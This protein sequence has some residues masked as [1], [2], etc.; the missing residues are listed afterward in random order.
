MKLT[1]YDPFPTEPPGH[2]SGFSQSYLPADA[3]GTKSFYRSSWGQVHA[4]H[5]ICPI[6]PPPNLSC[7]D[8]FTYS[9]EN[10]M[11]S[12]DYDWGDQVKVIYQ[13]AKVR[14]IVTKVESQMKE[15]DSLRVY[16]DI[17]PLFII[18]YCVQETK[19]VIKVGFRDST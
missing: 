13:E 15:R 17:E 18:A 3:Q 8:Y 7:M 5:A 10:H 16:L 19:R 9:L 12:F 4:K 6:S 1:G 14:V 2:C 11:N